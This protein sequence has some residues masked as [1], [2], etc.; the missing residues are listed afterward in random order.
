MIYYFFKCRYLKSELYSQRENF[1][2]TLGH[3]FRVSLLAQIRALDIVQKKFNLSD[4]EAVFVE[5][6]N[7]SC[8]YTL[9]MISMMLKIYKIENNDIFSDYTCINLSAIVSEILKKYES[10][11]KEKG[12]MLKCNFENDIIYADREY[13]TKAMQILINTVFLYSHKNTIVN[14]SLTKSLKNYKL[15][16]KYNGNPISNEE[17]KRM[18]LLN[19]AYSAVGHGIQ[20]FLCKKIMDI[21]KWEIR[22]QTQADECSFVISIPAK[23]KRTFLEL[24]KLHPK[25]RQCSTALTP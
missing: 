17:Y 19:P 18:F 1:I 4:N 7:N 24:Q 23:Q 16:V 15:E 8:K 21:H 20:M 5:E 11:A 13:F 10:M 25:V 12:I 14:I 3:D 2:K 22:F 6:I 9:D